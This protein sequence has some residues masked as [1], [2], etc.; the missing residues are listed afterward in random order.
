MQTHTWEES[1]VEQ[2]WAATPTLLKPA[3]WDAL[4]QLK[5]ATAAPLLVP[6]GTGKAISFQAQSV[7]GDRIRWLEG[8]SVEEVRVLEGLEGLRQELRTLLRV[9]LNE[10]EAH[11]ACYP[12]GAGYARHLDAFR[13]DNSRLV[14]LVCYLNPAW[15]S[16]HGGCL[17]L[18]LPEGPVDVAPRRGESAVFLSETIEHEVLPSTVERWSLACWFRR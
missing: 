13:R 12:P 17:R 11:L 6:A 10:V 4:E 1:L 15:E 8:A 3:F 7:R 18:H 14:S 5:H 16:A 9:P 2:G